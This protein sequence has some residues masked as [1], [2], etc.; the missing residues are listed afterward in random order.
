MFYISLTVHLGIILV[1][2]Q[3]DAVLSNVFIYF[4][5][6]HVSSKP[7]PVTRRIELYQYIIW[8]ISLCVGDCLVCRSPRTGIPG[9]H[10]H[11]VI[12]TR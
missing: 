7:V 9:S 8:Y 3:L 6:L 1:N 11:S 12:Y 2:N 10:L 4:T 5:S